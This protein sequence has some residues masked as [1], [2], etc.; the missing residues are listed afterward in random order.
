MTK[1]HSHEHAFTVRVYYEDTDAGGVV[2]NAN[3]LKFAERARTEML[4]E[5]GLNQ[6]E[7]RKEY[8]MVFVVTKANIT[9]K[10]PAHLDDVL[11]VKTSLT[12][13]TNSRMTLHQNVYREHT[14]ICAMEVEIA[15][16]K[17]QDDGVSIK[18]HHTPQMVLDALAGH[19]ITATSS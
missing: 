5:A 17:I 6:T 13:H 4:R 9:Y 16:V 1:P 19:G 10:R 18:A 11:V 2:Y 3:Y 14:L 12:G 15:T 8:N 7:I